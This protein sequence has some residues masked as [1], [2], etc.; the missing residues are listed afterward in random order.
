M[1]IQLIDQYSLLHFATGIV[2]YFFNIKFSTWIC[3]HILFEIVENSPQ[4]VA[5]IDNSLQNIWPGGK[6]ASDSIK[7]SIGDTSCA[8]IGWYLAYLIDSIGNKYK[9][10]PKHLN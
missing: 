6:K 1:G 7:N 3:F 9:W 4:G 8:A 10:Y 2:A 5:F